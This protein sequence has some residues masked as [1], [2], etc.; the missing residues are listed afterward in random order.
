MSAAVA[1]QLK[2]SLATAIRRKM[3]DDN[4]SITAFARKTKTGRNSVKRLL[5]GRNTAITLKTMAKAAEALNLKI[6]LTIKP[7][8]VSKLDKI[9]KQMVEATTADDA[10]KLKVQFIEGFYG[11]PIH[12]IHAENPAVQR[13]KGVAQAQFADTVRS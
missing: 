6:T 1:L 3:A 10:E 4:L 11:K 12:Q 9:A 2:K 8:P 13:S 7:L 5:D